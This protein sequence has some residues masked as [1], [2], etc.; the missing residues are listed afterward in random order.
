MG[1]CLASDGPCFFVLHHDDC[2]T[3]HQMFFLRA[4][5]TLVL[6]VEGAG[7]WVITF[8]LLQS[9][10]LMY[11]KG[12]TGCYAVHSSWYMNCHFC[13][14]GS[15]IYAQ[16]LTCLLLCC[17]HFSCYM[18]C[19]FCCYWSWMSCTWISILLAMLFAR[20]ATSFCL[21]FIRGPCKDTC[22]YNV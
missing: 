5:F 3:T 16:E 22:T 6:G 20:A 1:K 10:R 2:H 18:N 19:H 14:S 7:G 11:M 9:L 21:W 4:F 8:L 13:C 12:L 17:V 15:W